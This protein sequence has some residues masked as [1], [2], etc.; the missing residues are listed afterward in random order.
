MD[1]NITDSSN[2]IA[3]PPPLLD[4]DKSLEACLHR[5]RSVRDF[6]DL[7]IS[8]AQL[9]QLLWSAQGITGQ[10]NRK[11]TPPSAGGLHPLETT[12]AVGNVEG[13]EP[14]LFRYSATSHSLS[15]VIKGDVRMALGKA[16]VGQTWLAG[17]SVVV[18]FAAI[19]ERTT[20]K[21]GD[22]GIRYVHM[23]SGFAAENLHLQAVALGLGT[24][25]MGA[26]VDAEVHQA[27]R[28]ASNEKPL[29]IL[30]IGWPNG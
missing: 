14:G 23:D 22:R 7:P 26:F 16:A 20:V 17:A 11:R 8:A 13:F 1:Q 4:G 21:Y 5:R 10:A 9:S 18:V 2:I 19:Y 12:V 30:P 6:S 25:I 24:V 3:L 29:L 28:L 15:L 27:A